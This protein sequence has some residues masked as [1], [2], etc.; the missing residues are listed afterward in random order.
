MSTKFVKAFAIAGTLALSAGHVLAQD[1]KP[2]SLDE[3]LQFVKQGQATEAKQNRAREQAFARDKANQAA[4]LK[5]AEAERASQEQRSA[6]LEDAFEANELLVAAKQTQLK[7]KL[8]TLAELFGHLT[9]TAGD[10]ASTLEFSITSAQYPGREVF[11]QELID[12]M[13][14]SDKL[15]SIEEIERVW[16]ELNREMVES[17]QVASFQAEVARPNGDKVEQKVVRIGV[18]NVISEEGKYLQY[19]PSKGSLEE[20]ARQPSGP[21]LAWAQELAASTEGLHRFGIDPTGP[22]G[23][24]FLAALIN[25]PNLE[26]RWHQGGYIGYAITAL[27]VFGFLLALVRLV[28]LSA[29]SAKVNSQL[30]SDKANEN[31]PLG[32]VLKIH[33]DNPSMDT[34]TLELKL[35]EGI[36]KETPKLESGLTLLKIISAIAPLMGLLGTVT[37][38]IV[39][40]QAITIFGAGDPKAMAGGISGA[41]VTTVLG[42]LVAIPTVL[43]HTIVN[44]RA[45]RIIHVLNE[46]TTGIIAEHT[47]ANLRK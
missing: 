2:R 5:K 17:G 34:E 39:T 20:L 19:E 13:S 10:L 29:V 30:K 21:Y 1:E 45:Q 27:G 46:Q 25:S 16:Y 41:L 37:G 6:E 42:L 31:N 33:E 40:F 36:L 24:S 9:S 7:E 15:P 22:S 26:E 32:R 12:K 43:L 35:S 4:E 3:L 8:G 47:E 28:Y 38:M 14:G 23:G 18:F 44:G 11:L